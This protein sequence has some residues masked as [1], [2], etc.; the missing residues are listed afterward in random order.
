MQNKITIDYFRL[1]AVSPITAINEEI[2]FQAYMVFMLEGEMEYRVDGKS[3][4]ISAGEAL[5]LPE[6]TLRSRPSSAGSAKY[7]SMLF[8]GAPEEY[9]SA[10][11]TVFRHDDT[12]DI[13][14]A[15]SMLEKLFFSRFYQSETDPI[16]EKRLSI[17]TELI[18]NLCT[19]VSAETD[20]NPYV[21]KI[22]AYIRA[23]YK[24]KLTLHSIAAAVH[25]N[26]SYCATLFHK[27][28]GETIGSF[29]KN[30]R[31]DI[32]KDELARGNT[33]KITAETVGFSD[34]YNFSKWFSK[35]TGISPSKYRVTHSIEKR[36]A[37]RSSTV[38]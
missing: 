21:D 27:E 22:I 5:F 37:K 13:I 3:V 15:L 2:L 31:L 10:I 20:K 17:L 26:P 34:P 38:E 33:V 24:S 32:A 30:F 6:G 18:L 19:S 7:Y 29:I 14:T 36:G 12:P 4:I 23:N 9:A 28:T 1:R 35:A 25:L 11:P 16:L 8:R